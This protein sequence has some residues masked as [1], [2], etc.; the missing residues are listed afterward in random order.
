MLCIY[1][2]STDPYFNI[3]TDEY[4]FRH[5]EEDCFMLWQNDNAIIVGKHQNTLAEINYEYVK[6]HG[7]HVVRR[8]SGGGAVYH[9]MGNLNFSFTATGED[10]KLIDFEKYTKPIVEVLQSLGVNAKFEGRNDITIDGKKISGNAEHIF[11]NKILHHG[12]LLFSSQMKNVSEALR[13]NPL[14]YQ[15]KAVKSIPKRVTNISEHLPEPLSIE[16]FTQKIMDYVLKTFPNARMYEFTEDDLK[17][18]GKIRDEKYATYEWNFGYSPDYNFTKAIKAPG[19]LLEMNLDVK[20][21]IIQKA[22]I[23][24]DFFHVHDIDVIERAIENIPHNE[25]KIKEKLST[26]DLSEYFE[27]ISQDDLLEAMF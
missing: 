9:D 23:F 8:L 27:G 14:K 13:V 4:I 24:G 25:S 12:T 17:K 26:F 1:H 7:I 15:D 10:N 16:A 20:N 11:K 19:G 21:G 3:A 2:K 22:K 6:E 18:I 5:I